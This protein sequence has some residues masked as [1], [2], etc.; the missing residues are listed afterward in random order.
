MVCTRYFLMA[1]EEMG[2]AKRIN[3]QLQTE[4][5]PTVP[6]MFP[7]HRFMLWMLFIRW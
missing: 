7:Y 1:Q 6:S 2:P 4:T 5:D 3:Y